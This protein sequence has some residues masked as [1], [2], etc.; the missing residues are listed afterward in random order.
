MQFKKIEYMEWA[1]TKADLKINLCRS[2][3]PDL[4]LKDLRLNL[5]DLEINSE[6]S[7]GYPPLKEAI[8]ARYGVKEENVVTTIGTSQGLF[9]VCATLLERGDKVL[10][11]EPAY[12]PLLAVPRLFGAHILRL[13]RKFENK[14]QIDWEGF[15]SLVAS[16]IKLVILTNLHNPS[17]ALL[18]R[19]EISKLASL[20]QKKGF[21]VFIDEIYLEFWDGEESQTAFSCGENIVVGSSLTKVYGLPGLRCGW[22][23]TPSSL[24]EQMRKLMDYVNVEQVFIGEQISAKI[25]PLLDAIKNKNRPLISQNSEMVKEFIR[26]ERKLS[27]VEPAQGVICFPKLE[28]RANGDELARV[29][30]EKYETSLVPGRFFERPRH[31]RLGFAVPSAVLAQGLKNIKEV[32]KEF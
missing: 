20:A 13:E 9:Y 28:T 29:L 15:E 16:N 6:Y 5:D 25:F 18:P 24:A 21:I 3:V 1:K 14:Y 27:W 11:E 4:A 19:S 8:A 10:V 17:G 31:F 26:E 22:L 12:E 23:L 7:Y 32:L 2:G 30:R